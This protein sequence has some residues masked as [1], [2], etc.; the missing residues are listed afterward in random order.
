MD[1][2]RFAEHMVEAARNGDSDEAR[3]ILRA[4]VRAVDTCSEQTWS[5]TPLHYVQARYIA[6]ALAEILIGEG[7]AKALGINGGKGGSP[8]AY[9]VR[10]L[11]AACYFLCA[12][13]F[14]PETAKAHLSTMITGGEKDIAS[15]IDRG[16]KQFFGI[17]VRQA[18]DAAALEQLFGKVPDDDDGLSF[19]RSMMQPY[20]SEVAAII[21]D[22]T[23]DKE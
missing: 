7:A 13:G 10:A 17:T 22:F 12:R 6:D 11:V 21:K 9:D 5:L 18:P 15:T 14:K 2:K 8:P 23:P 4:F 20:A 3:E 19:Y 1:D 16:S